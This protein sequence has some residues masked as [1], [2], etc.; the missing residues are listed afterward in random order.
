MPKHETRKIFYLIT[1]KKRQSGNEIWKCGN[2]IL[3]KKKKK[4]AKEFYKKYGLDT[5]SRTFLFMNN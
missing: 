2:V 5:S 3:Q 4:S 1:E